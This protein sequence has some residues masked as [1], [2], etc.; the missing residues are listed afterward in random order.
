[1]KHD[2]VLH[3]ESVANVE[4]LG[5]SFGEQVAMVALEPKNMTQVEPT[6]ELKR[7]WVNLGITAGSSLKWC[8]G[9]G[10]FSGLAPEWRVPL[11]GFFPT[12]STIT[13]VKIG[14]ILI[15]TW[16]GEASSKLGWTLQDQA[17]A[18]GA[19]DPW[20]FGLTNDYMAYFTTEAEFHEGAY[21]SCS[22][23][24]TYIGGEHILK[25]HAELQ[26]Q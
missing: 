23:L 20:F 14:D 26:N 10:L 21:D 7:R 15:L 24:F 2:P 17:R 12:N 19:K 9:G 8:V 16:P 13:Q 4:A 22:S 1:M 5:R 18:N 25:A 3:A 6:I 11:F